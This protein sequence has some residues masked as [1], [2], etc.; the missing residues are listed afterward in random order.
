MAS[1][2]GTSTRH[3]VQLKVNVLRSSGIFVNETEN[4]TGVI[5]RHYYQIFLD[6]KLIELEDLAELSSVQ[7]NGPINSSYHCG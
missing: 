4:K 3:S 1:I 5:N 7:D 2:V 6:F